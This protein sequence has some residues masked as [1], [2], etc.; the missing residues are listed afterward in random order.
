MTFK[1]KST[2]QKITGWGM[3]A[4][5]VGLTIWDIVVAS[6][7]TEGDTISEI[8]LGFSA[9]WPIIAVAFGILAGH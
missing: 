1:L 7:D 6:N 4:S 3:L 8:I 9:D 2:T 5:A